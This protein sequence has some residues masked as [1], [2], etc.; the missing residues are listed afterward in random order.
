[1]S[2]KIQFVCLVIIAF[3][4][5]NN[6]N[7]GVFLNFRANHCL[8]NFWNEAII[9]IYYVHSPGNL[10]FSF[11]K[12][13]AAWPAIRKSKWR[14]L[15]KLI[16]RITFWLSI[17]THNFIKQTWTKRFLNL[18]YFIKPSPYWFRHQFIGRRKLEIGHTNTGKRKT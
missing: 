1:M 13:S 11:S 2:I 15:V 16:T 7:L 10:L 12:I 8:L 14:R 18:T 3:S 5:L 9:G 6:Y 4:Y 17:N